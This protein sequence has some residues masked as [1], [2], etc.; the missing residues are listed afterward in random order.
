MSACDPPVTY[1]ENKVLVLKKWSGFRHIDL[2][3]TDGGGLDHVTD[4]ESL[5]RLV[6]RSAS[7]AVGASDWLDVATALLVTSAKQN[8]QSFV[9]FAI[10]SRHWREEWSCR[11]W[12]RAS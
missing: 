8:C 10:E 3:R 9:H 11:T 4:G 12:M 7:G 2:R 6:L 5:D 1:T